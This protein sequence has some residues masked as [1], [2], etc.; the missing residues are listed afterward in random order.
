M[1]IRETLDRARARLRAA[2][3][4][5]PD[6]DAEW[7]LAHV[8]GVSR[9]K[10]VAQPSRAVSV[11]E[12]ARLEALLA[13]RERREPLQHITGTA[14]FCGMELEVSPDVLVPRPETELL[15][16][17]AVQFLSTGHSQHPGPELP[18]ALDIGTG[19]GC[20]A[21]WLAA[22]VPEA[23]VVAVDISLRALA[24]ARR[25]AVRCG[26]AG[27][28]EFRE[29]DL[30]SP[31]AAGERFDLIVSNPPY[32]ASAEIQT[33]QPEV[34]RF[35]PHAAL[36]GGED[37][38]VFYRRLA[39]GAGARLRAGGRLMAEFGDGQEAALEKLFSGHNWIVEEVVADYSHGPRFLVA[40]VRGGS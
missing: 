8:L 2:G 31:V 40:R 20:L 13:R 23:R 29:G 16:E 10:A 34:A 39:A 21:L 25:N 9:M 30:L 6:A 26:V 37:G 28:V 38:L 36:D 5:P 7:L 1:T 22:R 18:A 15:A 19:S 17:R 11:D 4:E 14:A 32:I 3:I 24:V 33:L 12:A 35:D 27:R